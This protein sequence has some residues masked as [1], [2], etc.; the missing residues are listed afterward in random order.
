[1]ADAK[2]TKPATA[3]SI[4]TVG[5]PLLILA[6]GFLSVIVSLPLVAATGKASHVVGYLVGAL[7][8]IVVI[9]LA[10]RSDLDRRRSI[11]YRSVGFFRPALAVLAVLAIVAA[12]LH[13]W[14]LATE[15]AS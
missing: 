11:G 10:R 9:G 7:V 6:L 3:G 2:G 1:M 14:P 5:P 13:I 8:P 4:D 15:L 12:G